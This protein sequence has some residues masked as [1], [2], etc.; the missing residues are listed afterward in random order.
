M[1]IRK[2]LEEQVRALA[3]PLSP[4]VG[5]LSYN[6]VRWVLGQGGTGTCITY[7]AV[8]QAYIEARK[9]IREYSLVINS[10]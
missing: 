4:Q 3:R 10:T 8:N 9:R 2:E 7:D 6:L 1:K 5:L